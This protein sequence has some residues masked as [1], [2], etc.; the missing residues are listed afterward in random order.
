[1]LNYQWA[2]GQKKEHEF[3]PFSVIVCDGLFGGLQVEMNEWMLHKYTERLLV[4]YSP[5]LLRYAAVGL[6]TYNSYYKLL[7]IHI[8]NK[9]YRFDFIK[10]W[11][12]Q[13]VSKINDFIHQYP[14]ISSFLVFF[15]FIFL[16]TVFDTQCY[17]TVV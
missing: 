2:F 13:K 8:K 16:F 15:S 14:D 1:M 9:H 4:Q 5:F 11:I 3:E 7:T 17:V 6:Y 12:D 10:V